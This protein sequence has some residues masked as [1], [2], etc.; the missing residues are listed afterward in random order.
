MPVHAVGHKH[1]NTTK[2][3]SPAKQVPP[4]IQGSGS[5]GSIATEK[6][7]NEMNYFLLGI[8]K[9]TDKDRQVVEMAEDQ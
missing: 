6:L 5:Q 4:F 7:D 2:G 1:V 9:W 3:P 8:R